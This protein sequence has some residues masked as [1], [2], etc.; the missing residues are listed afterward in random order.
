MEEDDKRCCECQLEY[1]K[2]LKAIEVQITTLYDRISQ[3]AFGM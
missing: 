3:I 1:E 2:S